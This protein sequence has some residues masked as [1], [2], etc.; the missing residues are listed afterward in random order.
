MELSSEGRDTARRRSRFGSGK[1]TGVGALEAS[2]TPGS[3]LG[4]SK[5]RPRSNVALLHFISWPN[6]KP[7]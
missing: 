6:G 2:S 1:V 7:G 4:P 5:G 3:K